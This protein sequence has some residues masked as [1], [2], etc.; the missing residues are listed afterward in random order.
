M[1]FYHLFFLPIQQEAWLQESNLSIK[2]KSNDKEMTERK[3]AK[4]YPMIR[5]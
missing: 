4:Y 2:N 3:Y 5:Y 1:G